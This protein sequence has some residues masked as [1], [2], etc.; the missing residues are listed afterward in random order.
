M[1][2]FVITH[3]IKVNAESFNRAARLGLHTR[4]R[5]GRIYA[6]RHECTKVVR[7]ISSV[8]ISQT[9]VGLLV[10]LLSDCVYQHTGQRIQK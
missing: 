8:V 1:C 5:G 6:C 3:V 4:D 9:G 7:Q 2:Y 10:H